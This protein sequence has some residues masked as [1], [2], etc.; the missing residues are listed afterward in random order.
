[1][2]DAPNVIVDWKPYMI[3]PGTNVMGEDFEAYNRR[4]WGGSGWTRHLKQEGQK[5]G[6]EFKKWNWWP[7]TMKSHCL[8]KFA[9]ERNGIET[10]ES[11]RVLFNAL[12]EEGKNISLLD[13]LIQIGKDEL[14]LEEGELRNYLENDMGVSDVKNEIRKGQR[15][16]Q[17]S[18]VPYFIIGK[19][20]SDDPP[21]GLSGAQKQQTFTKVFEE[22]SDN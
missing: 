3:D 20:G 18:G 19:E 2:Q 5:D 11:N 6:A 4:R 9:Q 22:L 21:Y 8:V 7:N 1:M 13:V 16:Y 15:T 14:G 17:I 12:Y 10:S